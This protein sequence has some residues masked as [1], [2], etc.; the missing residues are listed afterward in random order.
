MSLYQLQLLVCL[1]LCSVFSII[2]F[3]NKDEICV[4]LGFSASGGPQLEGAQPVA[5]YQQRDAASGPT[6]ALMH[7]SS[8]LHG[9]STLSQATMSLRR[10]PHEPPPESELSVVSHLIGVRDEC[11]IVDLGH[12]SFINLISMQLWDREPRSAF[13]L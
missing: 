5:F 3:S 12:N 2:Y 11:I 9:T 6:G 4:C 1:S 7:L 8:W 10:T 13:L